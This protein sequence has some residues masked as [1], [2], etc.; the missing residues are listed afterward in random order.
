MSDISDRRDRAFDPEARRPSPAEA[1]AS[2]AIG[3]AA[4]GPSARET[5]GAA[6]GEEHGAPAPSPRIG[7]KLWIIGGL[8]VAVLVIALALG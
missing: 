3:G 7:P 2:S 4:L 1:A 6:R 8:L 5:L